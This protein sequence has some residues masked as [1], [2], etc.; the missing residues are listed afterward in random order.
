MQLRTLL[1]GVSLARPQRFK[2]PGIEPPDWFLDAYAA[3]RALAKGRS[4]RGIYRVYVLLLRG[5]PIGGEN[6]LGLYVG[7]SHL[8]VERRLAQHLEG[9]NAS[10]PVHRFGI[11]A[12]PS[13][14]PH[15]AGLTRHHSKRLEAELAAR[16][17]EVV[18]RYRASPTRVEGG[19]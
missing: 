9:T 7:E 3:A 13:F 5:Q 2:T 8:E 19:H 14:T 15:L 12:L 16:L 17:R 10:R 6:E 4:A 1:E 11:A 18:V